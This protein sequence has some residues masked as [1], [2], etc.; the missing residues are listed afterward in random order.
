MTSWLLL[1]AWLCLSAF[2]AYVLAEE[3]KAGSG[4]MAT[5]VEPAATAE[6]S[7]SGEA[8]VD[9]ISYGLYLT[10]NTKSIWRGMNWVDD[11]VFQPD[12]W[13][14][15]RGLTFNIWANMH[16]TDYGETVGYSD[17]GG[18][19]AEIDYTVYYTRT[20]G[21]F[22]WSAGA[23]HYT[24]P[25]TGYNSTSEVYAVLSGN[26]LFQPSASVFYDFDE[27]DGLYTSIGFS[28]TF[29]LGQFSESASASLC[30]STS[31]AA[32]SSNYNELYFGVDEATLTD[33]MVSASLPVVV[34]E[35]VTVSPSACYAGLI[36]ERLQESVRK[37]D[38]FWTG[39]RISIGFW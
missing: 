25:H 22:T 34:G 36:D 39:I 2:P 18:E 12:V 3:S 1:G 14:S 38:N 4:E 28:H 9:Q 26:L 13:V 24:Y 31:V 32:A 8:W 21:R 6:S 11:P 30:L 10:F 5:E 33:F 7:P 15:Y 35:R 16:T 17:C 23:T 19:F 20:H 37:E 27:G 29:P